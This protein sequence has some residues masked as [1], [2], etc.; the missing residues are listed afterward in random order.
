MVRCVGVAVTVAPAILDLVRGEALAAREALAHLANVD[1]EVLE[2]V[3][4]LL[5]ERADEV[6]AANAHDLKE[7]VGLDEGARDRLR[8]DEARLAGIAEGVRATR[9]LPPIERDV[10]TWTLANGLVVSER[11][12]PI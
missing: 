4:G 10:R 3:V 7:A 11:L 8:L 9:A 6:L 5:E 1:S 2:R 12:I